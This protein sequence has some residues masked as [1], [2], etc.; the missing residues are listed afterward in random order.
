MTETLRALAICSA[1]AIGLM[2][3]SAVAEV[4]IRQDATYQTIGISGLTNRDASCSTENVS[5]LI[6]RRT[7][8][9][10]AMTVEGFV[11]ERADHIRRYVNVFV[12]PNL[13]RVTHEAVL[14]GLQRLTW[15]GRIVVSVAQACGSGPVLTL[16]RVQ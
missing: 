15:E 7:F 13:D 10:D 14:T 16:D 6:V 2:A 12:P 9:A 3:R 5:G 8:D 1:A 4:R 11:V